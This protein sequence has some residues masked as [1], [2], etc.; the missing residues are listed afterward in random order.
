MT[1]LGMDFQIVHT[2]GH[3]SINTL[4]TVVE[5]LKP[6]SIIPIHTLHPQEYQALDCEICLLQ[7]GQA[8]DL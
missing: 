2:S 3:A 7:D 4:R 1:E 8:F 5:E 6:R